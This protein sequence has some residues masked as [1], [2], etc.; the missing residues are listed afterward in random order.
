MQDYAPATYSSTTGNTTWDTI[1]VY[2]RIGFY[3]FYNDD[4]PPDTEPMTIATIEDGLSNTI[5]LYERGGPPAHRGA[6]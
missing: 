5:M 1:E 6:L 4:I 3:G 2:S